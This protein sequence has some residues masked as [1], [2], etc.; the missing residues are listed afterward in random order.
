M[1]P[2][3]AARNMVHLETSFTNL[4]S[5]TRNL[6]STIDTIKPISNSEKLKSVTFT[7]NGSNSYSKSSKKFNPTTLSLCETRPNPFGKKVDLIYDDWFG[8]APLASSESS[9]ISSISSRIALNMNLTNSIEKCL[10]RMEN[11][12]NS[13][14]SVTTPSTVPETT[15]IENNI[16]IEVFESQMHTPKVMR[17]TPKFSINLSN[18][19]D[20]D[21][22]AYKRMGQ[23]FI[24]NSFLSKTLSSESNSTSSN[25]EHSFETA[26]SFSKPGYCIDN[27]SIL[28][29][30]P[31]GS[32][33]SAD[34]IDE[35][36]NLG[37]NSKFISDTAVHC[38]SGCPIC[39][40]T[41]LNPEECCQKSD[42]ISCILLLAQ[43]K[44]GKHSI[45]NTTSSSDTYYTIS[46]SDCG[47]IQQNNKLGANKFKSLE[48][49]SFNS[50]TISSITRSGILESHFPVYVD[51]SDE[52][53]SLFDSPQSKNAFKHAYSTNADI[54]IAE[55]GFIRNN[56]S[57]PLL[58]NLVDRSS[59][60]NF[61][62]RKI[63]PISTTSPINFPNR[64]PNESSV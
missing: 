43:Q 19:N 41:K 32:S 55:S 27:K 15:I 63:H 20:A 46:S 26:Q 29:N 49:D 42:H 6:E 21:N 36:M 25:D 39:P 48:G 16:E 7:R 22:L 44:H 14:S 60:N 5:S 33:K 12:K 50:T 31:D 52:N 54:H 40:C 11:N 1:T 37:Q 28:R 17:R 13:H 23:V 30:L 62:K 45:T 51:S 2:T 18:V 10:N 3:T 47:F 34:N 8:N 9:S 56:E 57:L 58:S 24:T 64:N 61:V 35:N 4:Q 59:P 53:R 38:N